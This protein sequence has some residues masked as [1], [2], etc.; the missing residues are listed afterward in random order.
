V[1]SETL[2]AIHVYCKIMR[3]LTPPVSAE[4]T[5]IFESILNAVLRLHTVL[6]KEWL[7]G[8]TP[9]KG[10]KFRLAFGEV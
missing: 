7:Q 10:F 3:I 9:A 2:N 1:L 6:G 4:A 5:R 8:V